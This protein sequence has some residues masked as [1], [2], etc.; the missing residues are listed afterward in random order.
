MPVVDVNGD[1]YTASAVPISV[2]GTWAGSGSQPSVP[3]GEC[4]RERQHRQHRLRRLPEPRSRHRLAVRGL[5]RHHEHVPGA[6]HERLHDRRDI[7]GTTR[8]VNGASATTPAFS[9][10]PINL[11]FGTATVAN[12]INV[13]PGVS[14]AVSY[15]TVCA[16][17]SSTTGTCLNLVGGT[18]PAAAPDLPVTVESAQLTGANNTFPFDTYGSP[19][20]ITSVTLYP[21]NDYECWAGDTPDSA[22]T[23]TISGTAIYTGVTPTSCDTTVTS[24]SASLPVYPVVIKGTYSGSVPT[25]TA[26]EYLGPNETVVLNALAGGSG[27]IQQEKLVDRG[28]VVAP[29]DSA[30]ASV[31]RSAVLGATTR[32]NTLGANAL[33]AGAELPRA[34]V[35]ITTTDTN[36]TARPA[37]PT[38][39]SRGVTHG[40][41]EETPAPAA[42]R[43]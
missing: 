41:A 33:A 13:D 35:A 23:Y 25:P 30:D 24:P 21:N 34:E 15:S 29:V 12:P 39:M 17:P 1:A 4:Q 38:M 37:P 19:T 28:G 18:A 42:R 40:G 10:G 9:E 26:T 27:S 5:H 32:V 11:S 31:S 43:P 2:V 6:C 16:G 20:Q 8:N 14:V 36:R 7:A 3:L 22:P